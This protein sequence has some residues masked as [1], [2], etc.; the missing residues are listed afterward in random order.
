LFQ[1]LWQTAH[2]TTFEV[3][4]SRQPTPSRPAMDSPPAPSS[5]PS[6]KRPRLGSSR[7]TRSPSFAPSDSQIRAG[8]SMSADRALSGANQPTELDRNFLESQGRASTPPHI[9]NSKQTP[10]TINIRTPQ[11]K[12][13]GTVDPDEVRRDSH[14]TSF[15]EEGDK[16]S[17]SQ[18]PEMS[19]EANGSVPSPPSSPEIELVLGELDDLEDD[20]A[21]VAIHI[22]GVEDDLTGTMLSKFPYSQN[23]D[24]ATAGAKLYLDHLDNG[25]LKIPTSRYS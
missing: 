12:L 4:H 16:E 10:V 22:D 8:R 17:E 24:N 6:R 19:N 11:Q 14:V 25:K 9:P 23:Q 3:T 1:T 18:S 15:L 13:N 7:S 21:V 2:R 20:S 5:E